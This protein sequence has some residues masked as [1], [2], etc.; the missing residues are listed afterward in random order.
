MNNPRDWHRYTKSIKDGTISTSKELNRF[1]ARYRIGTSLKSIDFSEVSVNTSQGYL[2]ALRLALAYSTLETLEMS[3]D[4]KVGF[5]GVM[6]PEIAEKI[7]L[8]GRKKFLPLLLAEIDNKKLIIKVERFTREESDDIRTIAQAV[9]HLTFHGT[10]TPHG[11]GLTQSIGLR[12]A[13]DKSSEEIYRTVDQ[14]FSDWLKI[15]LESQ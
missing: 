3:I 15:N 8:L 13:L 9:R 7:R 12:K 6:N 14:R 2:V 11:S 5:T 10:L 4:K 1:A